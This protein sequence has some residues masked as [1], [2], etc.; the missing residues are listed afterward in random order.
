MSNT[1]PR[2]MSVRIA[3]DLASR[4]PANHSP[5]PSP[6]YHSAGTSLFYVTTGGSTWLIRSG[7]TVLLKPTVL[8]AGCHDVDE[9]EVVDATIAVLSE[10]ADQ[11]EEL[12]TSPGIYADD[13]LFY[14]RTNFG[15]VFMLYGDDLQPVPLPCMPVSAQRLEVVPEYVLTA[16]V[17][18]QEVG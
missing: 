9:D 13:G 7:A 1:K 4:P 15:Q 3:C 10:A 5:P 8:P 16:A 17:Q 6:G 11:L 2:I 12:A 18:I 14:T